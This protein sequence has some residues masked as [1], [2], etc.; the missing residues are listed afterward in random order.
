MDF[1][2]IVEENDNEGETWAFYFAA[3]ADTF[4]TVLNAAMYVDEII[5]IDGPF[6]ESEVDMV[7]SHT[8]GLGNGYMSPFNKSVLSKKKLKT[9][10]KFL[11]QLPDDE[12]E[13]VVEDIKEELN[14]VFYKGG[15]FE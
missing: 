4:R 6:P 14:G 9:L 7:I 2:R 5:I 3:D 11:A 13:D 8:N 1:Y 12:D 10:E 15:I